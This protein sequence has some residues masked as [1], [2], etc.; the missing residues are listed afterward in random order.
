MNRRIAFFLSSLL[1]ECRHKPPFPRSLIPC[2]V[3]NL[4]AYAE[5]VILACTE[6]LVNAKLHQ[7]L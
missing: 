1:C 2:S 3:R 6:R 4:F 7:Y 5:P